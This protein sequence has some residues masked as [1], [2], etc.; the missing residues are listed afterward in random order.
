M[1]PDQ[2]LRVH[3]AFSCLSGEAR[4][5]LQIPTS[6]SWHKLRQYWYHYC[7]LWADP[8]FFTYYLRYQSQHLVACVM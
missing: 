5:P 4:L 2:G 7:V 3:T 8:Y 1:C 6:L